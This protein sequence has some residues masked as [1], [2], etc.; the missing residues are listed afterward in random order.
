MKIRKIVRRETAKKKRVAAYVRVS[1]LTESQ[2]DSFNAQVEYFSELIDSMDDWEAAGIYQDEGISGV[3]AQKRPGFMQ[4]VGDAE[5]GKLDL[6]LVKS[7]SRFGR[8][9]LEAQTYV[10]K[11]KGYG[12]EVKFEREQISTFDPQSEMIFNF[13]VTIAQEE[14]KSISQNVRWAYE[15][16]AEQGIRHLG[17]NRVLGFDEVEGT[18]T[19]NED[20]WV[21]KLIF[22]EYADGK[23]VREIADELEERGVKTLRGKT[24]MRPATILAMLRNEIYMGD[25]ILQKNPHADYLTHRPEKGTPF[26][27]YHI[28]AD[29]EAIVSEELWNLV[30]LGLEFSRAPGTGRNR[31]SHELRGK[32]FCGE[33]GAEFVRVTRSNAGGK[34]KTWICTDRRAGKH[35]N[36][37]QCCIVREEELMELVAEI[38][39]FNEIVVEKDGQIRVA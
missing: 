9:S 31:N 13:L 15:R 25:R 2:E 38:E 23:S 26:K 7:I 14:S 35:G 3:C 27:S 16:L 28:K 21:V 19:P 20:A 1:T 33:C 12:V 29:H 32:I 4:M 6:I 36:G 10:H 8:N 37:C 30:Q 18:L 5:A 34:F 22:M 39:E 11:L 24:K 17:N